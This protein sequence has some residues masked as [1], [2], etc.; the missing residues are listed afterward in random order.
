LLHD[1][2]L[3]HIALLILP[4]L[5]FLC[6]EGKKQE[7]PSFEC[8]NY[9]VGISL[10]HYNDV[11]LHFSLIVLIHMILDFQEQSCSTCLALSS[12]VQWNCH[13]NW[14][15]YEPMSVL[16]SQ[17][18]LYLSSLSSLANSFCLGNAQKLFV[19]SQVV[20]NFLNCRLEN[21]FPGFSSQAFSYQS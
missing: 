19:H 3:Q 17:S 16:S 21:I 11:W 9:L 4:L 6:N 2:I 20:H 1:K 10:C 15:F 5:S 14:K 12:I 7:M 8:V 18:I 13:G